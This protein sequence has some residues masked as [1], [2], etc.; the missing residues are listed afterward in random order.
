MIRR[1]ACTLVSLTGLLFPHGTW[2]ASH[3]NSYL[4]AAELAAIKGRVQAGDAPWAAAHS[5]LIADADAALGLSPG[6]VTKQGSTGHDYYTEA[7]YCGWDPA[8]S[9]C[10]ASCCDGQINPNADRGDYVAAIAVSH[11]VRDLGL[12]YALTGKTA[13][14]D[15]AVTLIRV[16]CLDSATYMTPK[17]TNGQSEIE[18]AITIPGMFYGADLMWSYSGWPATQRTAFI[19]WTRDFATSFKTRRTSL[20][21]ANFGD[22]RL[23]FLA[24]AAVIT[25]DPDLMAYVVGHY[26]Q[27]TP[28]QIDAGGVLVKEIGRT[29]SLDYATYAAN[30]IIQVAEIARH[31]GVDLYN[32]QAA[33]GRGSIHKAMRWL[34]PYVKTPSTWPHPQISAYTGANAAAFELA[35]F[36]WGEAPMLDAINRWGR[37]VVDIRTAGHLTLTHAR[38]AFPWK[39]SVGELP[40]APSN[41]W[42]R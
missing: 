24:N 41:L 9:P 30:A 6:S 35:Y 39:V 1:I 4:N 28:N 17:A 2:A 14:A 29:K 27:L 33:D 7:P 23:V 31:H 16:W 10:G 15:K 25:E 42:V 34:A 3:P 37:P 21:E 26:R 12:A 13:Y 18:L 8:S 38:G 20:D 11:A 40:A 36:A 22:W 19:Q 5:A 32:Y